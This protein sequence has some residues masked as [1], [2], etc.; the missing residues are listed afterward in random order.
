VTGQAS[1]DLAILATAYAGIVAWCFAV[2]AGQAWRTSCRQRN[3]KRRAALA[4]MRLAATGR[5][6]NGKR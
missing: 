6:P 3:A 4:S 1:T 5:S 2:R